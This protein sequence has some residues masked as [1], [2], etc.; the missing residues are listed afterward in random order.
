M[1]PPQPLNPHH[2]HPH[3]FPLLTPLHARIHRE[4]AVP[5]N[6][7]LTTSAL[8]AGRRPT[9][10][11]VKALPPSAVPPKPIILNP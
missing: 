3:V 4:R 5:L 2:F 6:G 9:W 8:N 1:L 7:T 10:R 11:V